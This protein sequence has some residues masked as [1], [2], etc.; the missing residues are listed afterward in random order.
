MI[1]FALLTFLAFMLITFLYVLC[2]AIVG[3][4]CGV[5]VTH[6]VVGYEAF[7]N[8]LLTWRGRYWEYRI[9]W[10]PFGGYTKFKNQMDDELFGDQARSANQP[11]FSIEDRPAGGSL[12]AA[13]LPVKLVLVMVGPFLQ[14]LVAALLMS[15]AV[16]AQSRQLEYEPTIESNRLAPSG[17][18]GLRMS[19]QAATLA[20]Q[21][22]LF[23]AV[24]L[25]TMKHY[26]YRPLDGWSGFCG[27]MITGGSVGAESVF[28]WLTFVG[29]ISAM[30][31]AFNL[32]P[33][34]GLNGGHILRFLLQPIFGEARIDKWFVPFTICSALLLMLLLCRFLYA[35]IPWML[36][37]A[38]A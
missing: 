30:F 36:W 18:P 19:E 28:G 7:G 5:G 3:H 17:I 22:N 23:L 11:F 26:T 33:L 2:Q 29:L 8:S 21:W 9:G 35:D 38:K 13:S 37:S 14:I 16:G 4:W 12:Q 6:V 24:S 20:G 32:I 15:L 25:E 31:G 34:G 10:L 1:L 27:W